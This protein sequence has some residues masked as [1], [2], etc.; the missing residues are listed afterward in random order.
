MNILKLRKKILQMAFSGQLLSNDENGNCLQVKEKYDK[1]RNDLL[2]NKTIKKDKIDDVISDDE[3]LF[4]CPKNWIWDRLGNIGNWGA[5]ATPLRSNKEY[6]LD[7]SIPWLK[8]GELTDG[9]VANVEE[10]INE[11]ALKECSLKIVNPGDVMIAMYGATIGKLGIATFKL[12]TNQACCSC[13]IYG[14]VESKYLFYYLM[15]LKDYFTKSGMGGAQPNISR[16]IIINTPI[17]IPSVEYQKK[18]CNKI[19]DIFLMI[20]EL[21]KGKNKIDIIKDKMRK[22]S[23]S[24]VILNLDYEL[25]RL[26]DILIYE[27]PTKYIVSSTKYNEAY[28]TPVLTAGKSFILG[29]TNEKND[30]FKDIPVIIFDDFTTDSKYVD[31]DFKVKSSAMKILHCKEGMNIKYY[32][33]FLQ[34]L[35]VNASTHKRYWIS[36]FS[37]MMVS[38]PPKEIQDKIVKKIENI[39]ELVEQI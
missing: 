23:I 12:T 18:L 32:Y 38:V 30:I 2:K 8:T 22:K 33:Y 4:Q 36:E 13:N 31:F 16:E 27:Q 9:Y 21:E 14:G 7:G 29:Y 11:K 5:G 26:G 15:A 28:E 39:L 10:K 20:D 24:E 37:K 25:Q 17:C 3:K 1:V 19:D 6:Y 34:S 35:N